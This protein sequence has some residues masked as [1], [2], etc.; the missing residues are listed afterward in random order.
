MQ[1]ASKLYTQL[2]G[3][4]Q[5]ASKEVEELQEALKGKRK[6]SMRDLFDAN[7]EHHVFSILTSDTEME[8][9]LVEPLAKKQK[10][11]EA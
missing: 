5:Q 1:E 11:E 10:V 7:V 6:K 4:L 9:S 2:E 8:T 3:E